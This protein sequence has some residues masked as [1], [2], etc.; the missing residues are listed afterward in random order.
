MGWS[1]VSSI[2]QTNIVPENF[3]DILLPVLIQG[4]DGL[5]RVELRGVMWSL[6]DEMR[7][8][9]KERGV[10]SAGD[11]WQNEVDESEDED[12][13][14]HY[15]PPVTTAEE[16]RTQMA[17]EAARTFVHPHRPRRSS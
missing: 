16:L 17:S 5:Q 8:A 6:L 15:L 4:W 9:L 7:K 13:V 14:D 11:G 2:T 1:C 3:R 10:L 12:E